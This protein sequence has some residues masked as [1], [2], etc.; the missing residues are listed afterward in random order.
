MESGPVPNT[1][2]CSL[3]KAWLCS[4]SIIAPTPKI[5]PTLFLNQLNAEQLCQTL[6]FRKSS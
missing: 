3:K 1:H 6:R 2:V 4:T 5:G